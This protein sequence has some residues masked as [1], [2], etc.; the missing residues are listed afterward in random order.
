M[1]TSTSE[2][3][4]LEQEIGEKKSRLAELRRQNREP[5]QDYVLDT[6][7]GPRNLSHFFGD[8]DE[9]VVIHNMGRSC[10]YCSLWADG[11]TGFTKHIMSRAGFVLVSA[12][13]GK[14][15]HE[16]ARARGWNMPVAGN[17]ESGFERDMGFTDDKGSPWPGI[18]VFTREDGQIYRHGY[19]NLGEGDAFC[20]IWHVW[21]L[22]PK[23]YDDWE[24]EA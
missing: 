19:S 21:D 9:L 12:D 20:A 4:A 1:A 11:M 15:V 8:K 14:V 23:G 17:G 7:E 13:S 18:S 3:Q 24:P 5:V 2:I 6:F 16:T 10:K 22:F